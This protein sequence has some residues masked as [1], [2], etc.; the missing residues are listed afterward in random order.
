MSQRAVRWALALVCAAGIAGMIVTSITDDPDTAVVFGLLTAVGAF[1]I[2]LITSVTS[3]GRARPPAELAEEVEDRV[4]DLLDTGAD[5]RTVRA[6]VR[7]AV[8]LG[9]ATPS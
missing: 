2:V 3:G 6:L 5:E 1:G 8:R 7:S 4:Q 9:R